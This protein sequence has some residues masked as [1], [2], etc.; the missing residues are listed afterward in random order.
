[1]A[2]R[3]QN[4]VRLNKLFAY[5]VDSRSINF[6]CSSLLLAINVLAVATATTATT[7]LATATTVFTTPPFF[8]NCSKKYFTFL[9]STASNSNGL[10]RF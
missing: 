1:M 10:P 9:S 5:I 8:L 6:K 7:Y 3:L 4:P 2:A